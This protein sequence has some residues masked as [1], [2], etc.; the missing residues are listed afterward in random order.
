MVFTAL[1]CAQHLIATGSAKPAGSSERTRKISALVREGSEVDRSRYVIVSFYPVPLDEITRVL[2]DARVRRVENPDLLSSQAL[3]FATF[4]Q[5]EELAGSEHVQYIFPA[6]TELIR[7]VPVTACPGPI[8]D[9]FNGPVPY[10][11]TLGNGWDGYGPGTAD[12]RLAYRESTDQLPRDA[13]W[14]A[15][16]AAMSQWARHADIRF[17]M[18]E[19]SEKSAQEEATIEVHFALGDHGDAHPFDGRGRVLAHAFYPFN[20]EPLAGDVH[21]DADETWSRD[22]LYAVLL[23]EFGHSLGLGHSDRPN[24]VMYPYF[25]ANSFP[26]PQVDDIKA[27]RRLYAPPPIATDAEP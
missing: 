10:V 4:E 18:S 27:L 9:A 6:S 13:V 7:G 26:E 1:F 8:T 19:L 22:R 5:L 2:R 20:P 3:V 15:I 23:H 16:N 21:V 14:E 11:A 25:S 12:L 24:A 17:K